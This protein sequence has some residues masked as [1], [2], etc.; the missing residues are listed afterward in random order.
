MDELYMKQAL[1]LAAQGLGRTSP[2]PVVGAVIVAD[3]SIVGQGWHQAAG[4]PHAE[5]HALAQAGRLA[6]NATLYVTLEPCCHHGRTGPCTD[7]IIAAGV[8]RVVVAMT[9]P[10]PLVRGKGIQKLRQHG[11][12]VLEGVCAAE[13]AQLNEVFIKWIATGLP[14][15]VLKTA[16]TLDGKIA[17][18]T[19]HSKWITSERSREYVH[20]LRNMYD[21]ILVGIGTVLA[22]DP[23]LTTRL[24]GGGKNP[25]RVIVDSKGRIPLEAKLLCDCEAPV[26]IAVGPE[27]SAEKLAALQAK[28]A[29]VLTLPLVA[30]R[31]VSLRHLFVELGQR[32]ITSILVEGGAEVNA[33]VLAE[34][35][36][37]KVHWFIAPKIIGG[38]TAPGPVGGLGLSDMAQATVLEDMQ[39]K[40][41]GK[42]ILLTAY[43]QRREGRDVYRTCGRIGNS[44]GHS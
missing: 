9:D 6:R 42:D 5:V 20:G 33:S 8:K 39:V 38:K 4:T 24:P 27:A 3:G 37:D 2:N 41:I 11:L 16:I 32:N 17:T 13:A 15:G 23:S 26:I 25:I 36:V 12:E 14:F 34:N 22:D 10:N 35:V 44:E 31:G 7:A 43:M 18:Y 30:G 28:G 40:N 21:A 19:G 29:E 1:M